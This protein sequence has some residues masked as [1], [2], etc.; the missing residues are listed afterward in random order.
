MRQRLKEFA[1]PVILQK[2][3]PHWHQLSYIKRVL[4]M[5][6]VD[7]VVDV[8]ANAGQYALELR[9]LGYRGLI[10]SFEPDP[11]AYEKL[12]RKA[13]RDGRWF[14]FNMALGPAPG[15]RELN[16]ME[17]SEFNSFRMPT[18]AESDIA[19]R[20]NTVVGRQ[21]VQVETLSRVLLP[22]SS[23]HGFSRTFLK[24][25]TQGFDW[26]V[27]EGAADALDLII[28]LQSEIAVSR[29][30]E[31]EPSWLEMIARYEAAGFELLNLFSVSPGMNKLLYFDCY[32]TRPEAVRP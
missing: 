15:E 25:D 24:M 21:L 23:K 18:T 8:G 28:G 17:H 11:R 22:L 3:N 10:F 29:L 2:L 9:A 19:A 5:L 13:E 7:C 1:L 27:F 32:M 31:G 30:Y 20:S 4:R 16:L 6:E 26:E 12:E 14:V